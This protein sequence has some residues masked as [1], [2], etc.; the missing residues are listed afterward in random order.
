MLTASPIRAR[1]DGQLE[2][3]KTKC[4]LEF[5]PLPHDTQ[6]KTFDEL[7]TCMRK[8]SS[9]FLTGYDLYAIETVVTP[10][11]L[12]TDG[13]GW[14]SQRRQSQVASYRRGKEGM[15]IQPAR[16]QSPLM[17]QLVFSAFPISLIFRV[18]GQGP[19]WQE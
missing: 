12:C 2:I 10:T 11:D 15:C 16:E 7:G 17:K 1:L 14:M 8:I 19:R 5:S 4:Q 13:L 6:K 18:Q 9:T 3:C